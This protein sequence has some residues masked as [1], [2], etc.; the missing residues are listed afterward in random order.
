MST[1]TWYEARELI[2]YDAINEKNSSSFSNVD[3]NVIES[4]ILERPKFKSNFT[5]KVSE[6]NPEIFSSNHENQ[7]IKY[8][9]NNYCPTDQKAKAILM[10][11]LQLDCINKRLDR[12][13]CQTDK[14]LSALQDDHEGKNG[15]ERWFNRFNKSQLI[16]FIWPIILYKVILRCSSFF[17]IINQQIMLR[18]K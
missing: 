6:N 14:L 8:S 2:D 11:Q 1:T 16:H 13:I 5:E 17:G 10:M 7:S 18:L 12:A 4:I 3:A 15:H 9:N